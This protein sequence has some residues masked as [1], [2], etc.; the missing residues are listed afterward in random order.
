MYKRTLFNC[1]FG[2]LVCVLILFS[3][4]VKK[5]TVIP[6]ETFSATLGGVQYDIPGD[7]FP[8]GL[9]SIGHGAGTVGDPSKY[10]M[11]FDAHIK[12]SVFT[13]EAITLTFMVITDTIKIQEVSGTK[14][15]ISPE[16]LRAVFVKG[17]QGYSSDICEIEGVEVSWYDPNQVKWSTSWSECGVQKPIGMPPY[18]DFNFEITEIREAP[19]DRRQREIKLKIDF[20]CTLYNANGDSVRLENGKFDG[21]IAAF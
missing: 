14:Y 10:K 19:N 2:L 21:P 17:P 18:D 1:S 9:L 5:V 8:D 13:F 7:A 4:D 20:D 6:G 3:C 16:D 12:P 11:T 15:F